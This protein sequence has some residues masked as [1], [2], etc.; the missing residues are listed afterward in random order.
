M[1]DST[2]T[3]PRGIAITLAKASCTFRK[4]TSSYYA[5][6]GF[7]DWTI[8]DDERLFGILSG[9]RHLRVQRTVNYHRAGNGHLPRR[10]LD[11]HRFR[12]L[13]PVGEYTGI[14]YD[15]EMGKVWWSQRHEPTVRPTSQAMNL[16]T[17]SSE[18]YPTPPHPAP[19]GV[20]PHDN[21]CGGLEV[22]GSTFYM[23]CQ[24]LTDNDR[25]NLRRGLFRLV[26]GVDSRVDHP[27]DLRLGYGLQFDGERFVTVIAAIRR[28]SATLHYEFGTGWM[29]ETTPAPGTT[30][31]YGEV[32]HSGEDILSHGNLLS[33]A[34]TDR[35]TDDWPTT[36]RTGRRSSPRR[37]SIL[38]TRRSWLEALIGSTRFRGG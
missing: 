4:S 32:V 11:L 27:T 3:T 14:A 18:F 31:W 37:P 22:N 16:D 29:Y 38:T 17:R 9:Y 25:A 20:R 33:A 19:L 34:S 26:F 30:T 10:H 13:S 2:P 8:T 5:Y 21:K 28:G 12:H 24:R 7:R 36:A 35:A 23:R 1:N 15:R 6:Y